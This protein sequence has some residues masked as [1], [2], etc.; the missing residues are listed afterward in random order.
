MLPHQGAAAPRRGRLHPPPPPPSA[1]EHPASVHNT[2][3]ASV[4]YTTAVN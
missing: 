2:N 1:A 4:E 3:T